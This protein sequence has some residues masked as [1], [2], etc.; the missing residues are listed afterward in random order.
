MRT[1]NRTI[2]TKHATGNTIALMNSRCKQAKDN[3]DWLAIYSDI[4]LHRTDVLSIIHDY[5][6]TR[7]RRENCYV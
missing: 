3:P 6:I 7:G 5:Y 4:V 1:R 2:C